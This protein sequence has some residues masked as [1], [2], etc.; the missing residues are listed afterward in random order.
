MITLSPRPLDLVELARP[1]LF[2]GGCAFYRGTHADVVVLAI[3][4][5][6]SVSERRDN[7]V[8][9]ILRQHLHNPLRGRQHSVMGPEGSMQRHDHRK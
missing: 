9:V 1:F 2:L 3:T 7:N 4:T 8:A 6:R 5:Q